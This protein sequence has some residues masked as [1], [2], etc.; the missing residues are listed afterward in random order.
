MLGIYPN[1]YGSK[2]AGSR[3]TVGFG[4]DM[5]DY[6][7]IAVAAGGAWGRRVSEPQ[8][9]KET[10]EEAIRIILEEKRCAVIDCIVGLI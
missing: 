8:K 9:L 7:Q 2:A 1:G 5:P 6:A 10:M 3:L 4:P